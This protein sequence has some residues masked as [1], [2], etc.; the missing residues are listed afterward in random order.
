MTAA[1]YTVDELDQLSQ[2]PDR[3]AYPSHEAY[4]I[5]W[6]TWRALRRDGRLN[7]AEYAVQS[8]TVL[9]HAE[10]VLRAPDA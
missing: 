3:F 8:E 10:R 1:P 6:Y 2:S 5:G 9:A 7:E 4:L